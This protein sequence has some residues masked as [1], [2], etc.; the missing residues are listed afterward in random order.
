MSRKA[1]LSRTVL[2]MLER[3]E[4]YALPMHQ[5]LREVNAQVRPPA[6]EDELKEIVLGDKG[7]RSRGAV[8][9]LTDDFDAELLKPL[10]T[11]VGKALLRR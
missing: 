11:E 6:T 7:L 10:I 3:C 8:D 5:L 4:P 2:E 1:T 9:V